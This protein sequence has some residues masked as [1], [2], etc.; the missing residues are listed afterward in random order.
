MGERVAKLEEQ[1]NHLK[2]L[3]RA[4][5]RIEQWMAVFTGQT[6]LAVKIFFVITVCLFGSQIAW[7]KEIITVVFK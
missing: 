1:Y 2:G 6:V 7:I 5:A 3:P 4:V